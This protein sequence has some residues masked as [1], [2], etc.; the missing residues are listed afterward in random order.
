MALVF[1]FSFVRVVAQTQTA[2]VVAHC[3]S[4]GLDN[5]AGSIPGI[6]NVVNFVTTFD[7]RTDR[8]P[9]IQILPAGSF[10]VSQ[11]LRP[12]AGEPGVYE[13][14]YLTAD[15][16][17]AFVE[18]G[19]FALQLPTAD[20]DQNGV[21]DFAQQ[22]R[23]GALD[24]TGSGRSD[25]P[26]ENP[27]TMV[28]HLSRGAGS[29]TGSYSLTLTGAAGKV[30]YA[31]NLYL[32]HIFGNATYTRASQNQITFDLTRIDRSGNSAGLHGT[33]SY[34]V[35][36]TDA[37]ILPQFLLS[38]SDGKTYTVKSFVLRR[39]GKTYR[40]NDSTRR[41]YPGDGV[42]GLRQLGGRDHRFKRF[43]WRWYPRP[44]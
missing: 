16:S 21:P 7:G 37:L 1:A 32:V 10:Y 38:G 40:G 33:T 39:A 28:G 18:Y 25:W 36:S 24:F 26:Y 27:F 44:V 43:R 14:D 19:S 8:Q 9:L 11:E 29:L 23:N 41:R 31:G 3:Q 35:E 20:L 13:A 4:L 30:A 15:G 42:A 22:D 5:F 34:T 6:G 12:R 2:T 17:G